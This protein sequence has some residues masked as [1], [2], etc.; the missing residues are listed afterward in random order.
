VS[1]GVEC[2]NQTVSN[3]KEEAPDAIDWM[4]R[5]SRED[6]AEVSFRVVPIK[7]A[8]LNQDIHCRRANAARIRSGEQ[9]ILATQNEGSDGPLG[10]VVSHL[11]AAIAGV[12]HQGFPAREC[13]SDGFRQGALAADLVERVFEKALKVCQSRHRLGLALGQTFIR[14]AT[15]EGFFNTEQLRDSLKRLLGE[16]RAGRGMKIVQMA[17]GVALIRGS[18]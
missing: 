12:A 9:I 2:L 10:G 1:V 16:W 7:F 18:R 11:Q 5:N 3:S 4:I 14:R 13:I 17:A 8:C 6:V 15:F